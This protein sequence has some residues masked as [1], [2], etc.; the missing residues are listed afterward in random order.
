MGP[1]NVVDKGTMLVICCFMVATV[2]SSNI[3]AI[4]DGYP[5]FTVLNRLLSSTGVAEEI[6]SRQS[7]TLLA[8][9]DDT[10][11]VFLKSSR[12]VNSSAKAVEI[13]TADLL[14]FHVLLEFF[15]I[16]KLNALPT[17][18]VSSVATL[19]RTTEVASY[20][21]SQ[22]GVINIYNTLH[23]GVLVGPLFPGGSVNATIVASVTTSGADV[24][25]MQIGGFP[26]YAPPDSSPLNSFD[27]FWNP[28]SSWN[29]GTRN[30]A[31]M[32]RFSR[33]PRLKVMVEVGWK[34]I[35]CTSAFQHMKDLNIRV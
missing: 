5:N 19:L 29:T 35:S 20:S 28:P 22:R 30:V 21:D 4:L 32:A 10:L 17:T 3:T 27:S 2:H 8:L 9:P 18:N 31:S 33:D 1:G 26:D 25:V 24:S 6:N 34:K 12:I 23:D 13:Q 15:T 14:R 11:N 7:V 16:E